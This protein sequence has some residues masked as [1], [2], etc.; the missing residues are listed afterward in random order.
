MLGGGCWP[1]AMQNC[2]MFDNWPCIAAMVVAWVFIDTYVVVYVAL[3]FASD[4]LYNAIDASSSMAA[5]SML[6]GWDSCL[7]DECNP[8]GLIFF[9]GVDR[10]VLVVDPIFVF[11]G[12]H[13][14]LFDDVQADVGDAAIVHRVACRARVGC[15]DE[16]ACHKGLKAVR[17][18]PVG[19]Q[20]LPTLFVIF[21]CCFAVLRDEPVKRV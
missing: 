7:V 3:K 16:E 19:G 8:V 11:L 12:V 9:E 6:Q 5:I 13:S 2:W 14:A 21:G 15:A 17:G 1:T 4:S 20:L 18:M 10:L